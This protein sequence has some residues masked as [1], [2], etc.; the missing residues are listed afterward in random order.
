MGYK[1]K[2][3]TYLIK[4]E[5]GHEFHGAEARLK[6]MTY[7]E[8]EEATGADGGDGDKTGADGVKRFVDHLIEWNIDHPV[9]GE[10]LPPTLESVKA[11][12]KDLIAALN[13][14]WINSLIGVHDADPLPESSPAG[15]Q[16]PAVSAIPMEALSPSLAS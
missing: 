7:G 10:P 2:L 8:W 16:S 5:A 4:F 11:V 3:K 1:P 12:D 6:G 15:E 9:T 13:N 14:S